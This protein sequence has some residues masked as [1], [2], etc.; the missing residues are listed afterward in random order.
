MG[1][2]GNIPAE[3]YISLSVQH[4]TVTAT[5]SYTLDSGVTNENE[6]ALFIN[7]V[8]QEPGSS[9]AYTATGTTLT[10]SVAT[11]GTDSMY[12]LFL[13]KYRYISNIAIISKAKEAIAYRYRND[14]T[15]IQSRS[16]GSN[17]LSRCSCMSPQELGQICGTRLTQ[18]PTLGSA[19]R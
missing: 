5:T 16:R 18:L 8:R 2:I 12:C 1:F 3:K 11:A 14:T 9:Y 17:N 10:L 15:T 19:T 7:N 13:G 6:L 4:F